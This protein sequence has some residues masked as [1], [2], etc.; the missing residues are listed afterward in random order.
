[1]RKIRFAT[2]F[3]SLALLLSAAQAA[4]ATRDELRSAYQTIL[5]ARSEDSP[6]AYLPGPASLC[7]PGVLTEDAQADAL[8]TLNFLR[9]VAGL[10]P[11]TLDPLYSL[12][13]QNAAYLLSVNGEITHHPAQPDGMDDDLYDSART[14]ALSSNIAML[15]WT[16]PQILSEGV[17]YFARDDGDRNLETLSHRRWMLNPRMSST[18]FGL[19]VSDDGAS[20]LAMYAVDMENAGVEWDTVAWPSAGVFPVELMRAG[21]AWSVVFNGA[22]YDMDASAPTVRLTEENS[23]AAFDLSL[24]GSDG[25]CRLNTENYGSGPCLIFRPEIAMRG[26]AE[27]VQNQRWYVEI[28]GLKT[29]GG[30]DARLDYEIEMVSLYPQDAANVE[31]SALELQLNVGQTAFL[32]AA[33]IPEYADDLTVVWSSDDPSVAEVD[34]NGCVTAVAAGICHVRA[35]SVNGRFDECE[36]TVR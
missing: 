2:F 14:G 24:D 10:A 19:S 12:R 31:L 29:A 15:S 22:H 9:A 17:I 8:A 6:F 11:V 7:D 26:I 18:G 21:L 20:Y 1:M 25:L 16:G 36:I 33:V 27:Y 28:E 35:S 34:E 4:P 23:G 3:I 32:T 13:A 5:D 30:A